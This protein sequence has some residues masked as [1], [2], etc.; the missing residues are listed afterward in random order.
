[1]APEKILTD[2]LDRLAGTVLIDSYGERA[3]Y[4]NPDRKLKRGVYILTIKEKDGP[5]DKSSRLDRE[6]VYRLNIGIHKSTFLKLFGVLPN[7]PGKGETVGMDVDFSLPD[8]I[9]PHPVY[10][11]MGWICVLNPSEATF[12]TL[13]PLITEAY[14]Y[15]KEK[16]GKR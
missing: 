9:L 8:R 7:R 5:N 13:K 14:E 1:M 4:Y 6:K 16:Y 10:A 2:C 12:E 3:L 15:A 11:W